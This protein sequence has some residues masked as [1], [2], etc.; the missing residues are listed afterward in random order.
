MIDKNKPVK[1]FLDSFPHAIEFMK[2]NGFPADSKQF[3]RMMSIVKLET[4]L[5]V[6]NLNFDTFV[7]EFESFVKTQE[8]ISSSIGINNNDEKAHRIVGSLPCV[9]QLPLH[10]AFE[11]Y[12]QKHLIKVAFQ[13]HGASLGP[14]WMHKIDQNKPSVIMMSPGFEPLF[15]RSFKEKYRYDEHF[16]MIIDPEYNDSFQKFKDPKKKLHVISVVP[17][18]LVINKKELGERSVPQNWHDVIFNDYANSIAYPNEDEDLKNALLT[19][20][21]KLGGD[22]AVIQFAKN[23][24]LP[25]HP[26]QMVKSKRIEQKPA[27]MIMPYFFAKIALREKDFEVVWPEDGAISIPIFLAMDD[28]MND[29]ERKALNFFFTKESGDVFAKQGYFPSSLP[30]VENELLGDLLWIGWDYIYNNDMTALMQS[31]YQLFEETRN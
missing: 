4:A 19:Y 27:I 23:C 20:I 22:Q 14:D 10:K 9:V 3:K 2:I 1:Q 28:R 8:E 5:N 6:K 17:M 12:L 18:V 13:F 21:Y 15:N 31:C 29:Q 26:S 16:K 24:L 30:D 11:E 25:L 7:K